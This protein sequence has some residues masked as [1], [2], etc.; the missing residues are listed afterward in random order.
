MTQNA[1]TAGPGGMDQGHTQQSAE[2]AAGQNVA[3][4]K[5]G[6]RGTSTP[7]TISQG[8]FYTP[9]VDIIETQDEFMFEAD[10]PGVKPQDV[11]ITFENGVLT[12]RG[13]VQERRPES[14]YYLLAEYGVG[15]FYRSFT[16]DT[17]I[18]AEGIRAELRNGVLDLHVPKAESVKPRR[19]E[20][21]AA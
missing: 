10:M 13:N 14:Q 18:N 11:D 8:T 5:R 12:I 21:K 9:L 3:M 19:I 20:V 17:P 15:N 6:Q 4:E 2:Q 16:I 7:E 1:K